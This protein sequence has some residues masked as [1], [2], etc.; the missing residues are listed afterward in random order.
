MFNRSEVHTTQMAEGTSTRF[1]KISGQ[2]PKF[3]LRESMVLVTAVA[4][5]T[6]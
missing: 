3:Q 4:K 1:G 2:K 5:P 6:L